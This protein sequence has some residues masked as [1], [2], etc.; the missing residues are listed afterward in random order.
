MF[1]S[2]K[3]SNDPRR[4]DL[5][6]RILVAHQA[7]FMP[8]LGYVSK[9]AMGDVFLIL[10][11]TQFKKKYFENRNKI[12]FS[13]AD[14]WLWLATSV[15]SGGNLQNMLDVEFDNL[16]WINKHLKTI[17]ISY[18]KTKHFDEIYTEIEQIYHS[19]NSNKLV[20]FNIALI[21]YAFK[22]FK[23]SIPVIR[24]S[25]LKN[26]G[27]NIDGKSTEMVLSLCKSVNADILVAG[28]SGKDYLCQERFK[29]EKIQLVYQEFHHPIYKQ[30]HGQF[31]PYMSFIDILFNHGNEKSKEILGKSDFTL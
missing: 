6:G 23:I 13:N 24:V 8:W 15:K 10:D 3:R 5:P 19:I 16:K 4:A 12:R 14:G 20:E 26:K 21:L 2:I 18:S 11:D 7:E 25:E 30:Y 17:Q 22:K 29:A 27:F 1:E 28:K 31:L 9:A